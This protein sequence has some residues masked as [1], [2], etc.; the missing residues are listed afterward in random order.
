MVEH[1][2]LIVGIAFFLM[3][4]TAFRKL[5][6]HNLDKNSIIKLSILFGVFGIIG[7]YTGI[8]IRTGADSY[9][10]VPRFDPIDFDDR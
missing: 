6:D 10:W 5:I 3:R 1:I 8:S 2:G 4:L 7:T 9:I